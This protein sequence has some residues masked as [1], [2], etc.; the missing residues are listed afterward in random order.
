MKITGNKK[1]FIELEKLQTTACSIFRESDGSN[2]TI[3]WFRADHNEFIIDGQ[4]Y[5]FSKNQVI[6]LLNSIRL[7]LKKKGNKLFPI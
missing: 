5:C 2:L 4:T 7:L 1:E 6:F 3:L